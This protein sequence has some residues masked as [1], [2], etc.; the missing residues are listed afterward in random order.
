[1]LIELLEKTHRIR[2]VADC[3]AVDDRRLI[4]VRHKSCPT[5]HRKTGKEEF[6]V[7]LR[8]YQRYIR[9]RVPFYLAVECASAFYIA[10]IEELDRVKRVYHGDAVDQGGSVFLPVDAFKKITPKSV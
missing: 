7:P 8:D 2:D 10:R 3:Y 1:M 6:G 4:N 5:L 9:S